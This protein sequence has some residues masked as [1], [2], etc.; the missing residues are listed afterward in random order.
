[1]NLTTPGTYRHSGGFEQEVIYLTSR[2]GVTRGV[3]KEGDGQIRIYYTLGKVEYINPPELSTLT[4][5]AMREPLVSSISEML[6]DAKRQIF[7]GYGFYAKDNQSSKPGW[8]IMNCNTE[9]I[10]FYE[11]EASFQ[12]AISK[13]SLSDVKLVPSEWYFR[14]MVH[15]FGKDAT[16]K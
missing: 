6:W 1:V 5:D 8:F 2:I 11:S 7:A 13:L 3:H 10:S 14:R 16:D 4:G 9:K 12:S 15:D